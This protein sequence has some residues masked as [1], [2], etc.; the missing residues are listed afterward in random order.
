MQ[1]EAVAT[2]VLKSDSI[3]THALLTITNKDDVG[4]AHYN[5]DKEFMYLGKVSIFPSV[6]CSLI[7]CLP[8]ITSPQYPQRTVFKF[9]DEF[10][11]TFKQNFGSQLVSATEGS[12]SK[13]AKKILQPLCAKQVPVL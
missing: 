1:Y 4:T 9:L 3:T 5:S 11:S 8:V 13:S 10:L 2:R 7:F 12:L 6:C